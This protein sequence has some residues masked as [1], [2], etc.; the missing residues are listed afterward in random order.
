MTTTTPKCAAGCSRPVSRRGQKCAICRKTKRRSN[1]RRSASRGTYRG[2]AAAVLARQ[3]GAL[4]VNGAFYTTQEPAE[5]R[6]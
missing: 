6:Q 1:A 3:S 4:P 5:A 2:G